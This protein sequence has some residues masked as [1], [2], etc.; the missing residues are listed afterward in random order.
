MKKI[1]W[2]WTEA[3]NKRAEKMGWAFDGSSIGTISDQQ[4]NGFK[5]DEE[6]VD[7]VM[8]MSA[9]RT[10]FPSSP[11]GRDL[12]TCYKAVFCCCMGGRV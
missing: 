4:P 11:L 9:D 5:S 3:D 6:A 2:V 1:R 12:R 10:P 7:Y 8:G